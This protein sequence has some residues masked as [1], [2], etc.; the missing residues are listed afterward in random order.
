V[1]DPMGIR[2]KAVVALDDVFTGGNTLNS[3]ALRLREAGAANVTGLTFARTA[4]R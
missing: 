1:T 3:V 4:M 2:D